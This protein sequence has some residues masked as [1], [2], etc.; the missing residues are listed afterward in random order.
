MESQPQNPESRINLENFHACI[1]YE[2]S[3]AR[4]KYMCQMGRKY[5]KHFEMYPKKIS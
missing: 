1:F 4:H 5:I 3:P 2:R